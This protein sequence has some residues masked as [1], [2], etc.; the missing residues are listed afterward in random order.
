VP[1]LAQVVSAL[2]LAYDPAWA[3][4]WDAVGL[5]CGDPT[6]DV[7]RVHLAVDPV[8]AVVDEALADGA[9]LLVT[10]HPL[11]LGGTTSVAA[12]SAKGR[13]IHRLISG[14]CALYV[15]H[16]NADVADPGVSDALAGA[17]GLRELRPLQPQS[18]PAGDKLVTFVP[19]AS[20]DAVVDALAAAGA[21]VIGDYDRC[22]FL[23][24]GTGTFR[25]GST[26][27]PT[28]GA[29]EKISHVDEIRVEMVVPAGRRSAAVRALLAT[30][31]YEEPAYDLLAL[32]PPPGSRGLGRVGEL[33]Q[34]TTL[35]DF[36]ALVARSLPATSW[37]VRAA[38]DPERRVRAVAVCGGSGGSLAGAAARA[39]ADV[40][41]TADLKHHTTSETAEDDVVALVDAAHW[42][43][44][45]PWLAQAAEVIRSAATVDATVSTIVTDPWTVHAAG[46]AETQPEET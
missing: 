20:V 30:H 18:D 40:L 27:N 4:S 7:R 42:A 2:E 6:A 33:A 34:P 24:P 10:H 17:I 46:S 35:G 32:V 13:V 37:G 15:A 5:V 3:E 31:P 14:G 29:R 36:T 8:T 16:T 22:A 12:T 43:T 45:W 28:M 44:E 11:Y 9:Q 41:L 1:Q 39:G 21:G 26:A 25:P 38:G 23:S 19:A